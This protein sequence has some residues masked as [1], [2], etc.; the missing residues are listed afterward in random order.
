MGDPL[1]RDE[2]EARIEDGTLAPWKRRRYE[3]FHG[4]MT[5]SSPPYPCYFAVDAHEA[6]D[7]RYVFPEA[8]GS[9]ASE[10]VGDALAAYLDG[11]R[12]LAEITSLVVLFE[13]PARERSAEWYKGEFWGLLEALHRADPAP[14]PDG[15]PS[16]P[17]NPQWAFS[18]AGEPLFLVARAP[19]YGR[20]R[21]RYTPHGLEVTVQPRWVF[22]DLAADSER[23]EEA[24]ERI[25]DRLGAYD[26]L[27]TH[28]DVGAYGDPD[29]REWQQYFL[30]ETNAES[31]ARFPFRIEAE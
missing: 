23:G 29:T 26:D 16:D 25:R 8:P 9:G 13:P 7:L 17:E 3:T 19:I 31:L 5:E 1:T 21:S 27:P 20:R 11:A 10:A 4:T 24:R 15:V 18:Y 14:W 28:P 2:V 6:G 22:D 12:D 30:P